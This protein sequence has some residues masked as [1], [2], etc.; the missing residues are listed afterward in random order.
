MAKLC[1][2]CGESAKSGE[3]LFPAAFGGRRT[4]RG[5]YCGRHNNEFGRHVSALLEGLDIVNAIMGV[6]PDRKDEVRPALAIGEDGQRFLVTGL[7][8]KVA[9]PPPISETPELLGE[10]VKMVFDNEEQIHKWIAAQE[11]AGY[12]ISHGSIGSPQ[13]RILTSPLVAQRNL[14]DEPFMRG[15]LYLALTF[16]AHSY[17]SLARSDAL[18]AAREIVDKDGAVG[19]RVLWEPSICMEGITANPFEH[20]HT[21]CVGPVSGA[22]KVGALISLYGSIQFSIDLGDADDGARVDRVA[23]HVDPFA[24]NAGDSVVVIVDSGY[25]A[26]S[27]PDASR[28]YLNRLRSGEVDNPLSPVLR[29]ASDDELLSASEAFLNQLGI[30]QTMRSAQLSY[31]VMKLLAEHDQRIF[32]ALHRGISDFAEATPDLPAAIH[33]ALKQ[34]VSADKGAPRGISQHG[35]AALHVAK[36]LLADEILARLQAG[37]LDVNGVAGLL[38]GIEGQEIMLRFFG[39]LVLDALPKNL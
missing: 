8:V 33:A 23:T 12:R 13:T 38:S 37:A 6:I 18:A 31:R 11:S 39:N 32:S 3:H 24:D 22:N 17:P 30:F 15:L 35:E 2:I 4:N 1:I 26:L 9:P 34:F 7:E 20:G 19:D 16:L 10:S 28:A 25:L 14:G 27:G 21:V 5:I 29:S 36:A